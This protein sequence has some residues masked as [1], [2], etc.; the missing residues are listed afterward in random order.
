MLI[1]FSGLDGSGKS[2]HAQI[3]G[4]YLQEQGYQTTLLHMTHWTWVN[5][6]GE[7][8]FRF[9]TINYA[10]SKLNPTTTGLRLP[11]LIM[12]FIDIVRFW[13]L[14]VPNK[15]RKQALVCDRY[16]YDLG[17]QATYTRVMSPSFLKLYWSMIPRPTVAFWLDVHPKV[18]QQREGEHRSDYYHAKDSLYRQAISGD[19]SFQFVPDISLLEAEHFIID[20]IGQQIE[21][22]SN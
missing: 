5:W 11:Q 6:I 13:L 17:I 20:H 3:A 15:N 10:T 22:I 7:S 14:W 4:K 2:T 19:K 21:S 18:A 12:M 1:T 9:R 16:F 8:L